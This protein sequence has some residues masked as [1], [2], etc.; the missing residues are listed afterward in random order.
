[1]SSPVPIEFSIIY[2]SQDLL[3]EIQRLIIAAI[4]S[5]MEKTLNY[6]SSAL[7]PC[8]YQLICKM[9]RKNLAVFSTEPGT[10]TLCSS[11]RG[12]ERTRVLALGE[13]ISHTKNAMRIHSQN[14]PEQPS[15]SCTRFPSF[16]KLNPS[17]NP[18]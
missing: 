18:R 9:R 6:L 14:C 8:L 3:G 10:C 1:M 7:Y 13:C 16:F 17:T 2:C 11:E 5:V 4:C 15:G 12:T